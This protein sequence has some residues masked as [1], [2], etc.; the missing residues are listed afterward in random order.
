MSGIRTFT[1]RMGPTAIFAATSNLLACLFGGMAMFMSA[2]GG[3]SIVAGLYYT[4]LARGIVGVTMLFVAQQVILLLLMLITLPE[5]A[6]FMA[7]LALS[8][9]EMIS[10]VVAKCCL[11][12]P[13]VTLFVLPT[14]SSRLCAVL[15]SLEDRGPFLIGG[16]LL[17]P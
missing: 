4:A 7:F 5:F 8:M 13:I 1:V 10:F 14:A 3:Q 2:A 11:Y 17:I 9:K 16:D 12:M 15:H 6:V